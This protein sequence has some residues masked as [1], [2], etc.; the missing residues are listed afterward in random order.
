LEKNEGNVYFMPPHLNLQAGALD[1]IGIIG[2]DLLAGIT[3]ASHMMI[4][5]LKLDSEGPR[6]EEGLYQD[7][8]LKSRIKI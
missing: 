7:G 4:G 8:M 2:K 3:P 1:P 6:H 5:I